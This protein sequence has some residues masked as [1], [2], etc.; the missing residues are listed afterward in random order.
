MKKTIILSLLL[1]SPLFYSSQSVAQTTETVIQK[2]TELIQ[3]ERYEEA[4]LLLER[5]H[6]QNPKDFKVLKMYADVSYLNKKY[7]VFM[8][9]YTEAMEMKP[10]NFSLK[11]EYGKKLFDINEYQT[12]LTVLDEYLIN[13]PDNTEALFIKAKISK[14]NEDYKE[15]NTSLSKILSKEPS[16]LEAREM[17]NQMLEAKS[18]WAKFNAS[19]A[20][21]S[22]PIEYFSP[23]LS[24]GMYINPLL[25]LKISAKPVLFQ[26]KKEDN[27]TVYMLKLENRSFIKN[28]GVGINYSAGGIMYPDINLDVLGRLSFDKYAERYILME[29]GGERKPYFNSIFSLDSPLLVNAIFG[30]LLLI[31]KESWNGKASVESDFFEGIEN[32]LTTIDSYLLTPRLKVKDFD[33]RIGYGINFATTK[34]DKFYSDKS[35]AEI[36]AGRSSEPVF[37]GYYYPYFTPKNQFVNNAILG[38]GYSPN[39]ETN[40]GLRIDYG[41]IA[42]TEKPY[43][44]R[45]TNPVGAVYVSKGYRYVSYHPIDVSFSLKSYLTPKIVVNVDFNYSENFFY[46][47]RNLNL[48][49]KV[50]FWK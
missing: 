29:A 17:Y 49:L 41:F 4:Q 24:A 6:R 46:V 18:K 23:E 30:N 12:A 20:Y 43:Y 11:F 15:A 8:D 14:Y 16:N 39:K 9:L 3:N 27:V 22:Q 7:G 35:D 2:A 28:W 45:E 25:S 44:F 31:T 47:V 40:I 1:L 36:I 48:G 19:Y 21:N 34:Y 38:I 26:R 37:L 32:P 50:N 5:C 10:N 42:N 33:F 13:D